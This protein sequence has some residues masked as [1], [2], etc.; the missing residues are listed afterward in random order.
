M[1]TGK[2]NLRINQGATFAKK[3]VWSVGGVPA[4]LTG[5]AARMQ[6]RLEHDSKESLANLTTENDGI[7][8]EP[9]EGRFDLFLSAEQTAELNF[10]EAVYDIELVSPTGYVG[11][12]IEGKV[13]LSP[14]VTR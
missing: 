5:W 12:I 9:L 14:E 2:C 7:T 6:I 8:I 1:K 3:F 13:K 10:D 11:R 4:D